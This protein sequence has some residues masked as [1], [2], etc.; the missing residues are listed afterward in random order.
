MS[1][2]IEESFEIEHCCSCGVAFALPARFMLVLRQTHQSFY[3]P[4]GHSQSY[5]GK[6]EAERLKE[7]LQAEQRA[8]AETIDR[9]YVAERE[10]AKL[11]KRIG[12]GVCPCCTRNFTNL[13]R[14]MKT[15]HPNFALLPGKE[16]KRLTA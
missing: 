4:N 2:A 11:K 15:Q 7:Q 8:H 9:R 5:T 12:N 6:S 14:H 1:I 13:Q 10:A 16:Q 3:C